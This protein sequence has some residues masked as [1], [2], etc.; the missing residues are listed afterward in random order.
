MPDRAKKL[1]EGMRR[2][3]ANWNSNDLAHLY[4]GFGFIIRCGSKHDIAKHPKYPY[5]RGTIPR[6]TTDPA[7]GYI[8]H[9][10]KLITKLLELE[11]KE[12]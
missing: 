8:T 2:S 5:L 11:G 1:L 4:E 12:G 10:V 3:P 6:H 9:A 7:T